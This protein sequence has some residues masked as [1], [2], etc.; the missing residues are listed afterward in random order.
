MQRALTREALIRLSRYPEYTQFIELLTD[1]I[2]VARDDL[3]YLS[4]PET[5]LRIQTRIALLREL[6][7]LVDN[8]TAE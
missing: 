5:I 8:A 6:T 7:E 3:E 2:E 1:Q 4:S